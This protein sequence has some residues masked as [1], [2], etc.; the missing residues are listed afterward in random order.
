MSGNKFASVNVFVPHPTFP[1]PAVNFVPHCSE[2]EKVLDISIK[3]RT[4]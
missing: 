1:A 2:K 3:D 4:S